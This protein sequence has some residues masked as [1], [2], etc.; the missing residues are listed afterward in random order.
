MLKDQHVFCFTEKHPASSEA[1][2]GSAV[3]STVSREIF[4]QDSAPASKGG[5]AAA[6]SVQSLSELIEQE[7]KAAFSIMDMD[8]VGL[9]HYDETAEGG[10]KLTRRWTVDGLGSAADEL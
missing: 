9:Y 5:A 1:T 3:S 4:P 7:Q 6:E 2:A 10:N 8:D